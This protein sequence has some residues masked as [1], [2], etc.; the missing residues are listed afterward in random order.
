MLDKIRMDLASEI[1][2]AY[3]PYLGKGFDG[4][5]CEFLRVEYERVKTQVATGKNDKETLAWCYQNGREASEM[6]ILLFNNFMVKRRWRD[7]DPEVS[8]W[9]EELKRRNGLADRDD[10]VT[11]FDYLENDVGRAMK[12][13]LKV[14]GGEEEK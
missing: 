14:K 8:A 9:L 1:D 6:D 10:I 13:I 4:R 3:R 2:D 11:F 12:G 5:C 7:E